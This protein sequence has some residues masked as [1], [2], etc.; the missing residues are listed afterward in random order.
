LIVPD[1]RISSVENA[2]KKTGSAAAQLMHGLRR[3]RSDVVASLVAK[4]TCAATLQNETAAIW[5]VQF[6]QT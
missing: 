1:E 3:S 4:E 5:G 6:P 2:A